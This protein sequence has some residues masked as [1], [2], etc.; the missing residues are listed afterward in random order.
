MYEVGVDS[1]AFEALAFAVMAYQTIQG[2][3]TNVPAV[4]GARHPVVLGTVVP[5]KRK[6]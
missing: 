2:I 3:P 6:I 1:N 5:G 4:T